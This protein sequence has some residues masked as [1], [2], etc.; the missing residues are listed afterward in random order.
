MSRMDFQVGVWR[1]LVL[2]LSVVLSVVVRDRHE[3]APL[4]CHT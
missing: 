2:A 4:P 1:V 3:P